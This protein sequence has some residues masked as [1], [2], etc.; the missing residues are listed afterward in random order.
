M[1]AQAHVLRHLASTAVV[2]VLHFSFVSSLVLFSTFI[3]F[4]VHH[5]CHYTLQNKPIL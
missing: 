5:F 1:N 4:F 3:D 2:I